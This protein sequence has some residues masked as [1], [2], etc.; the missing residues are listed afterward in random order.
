MVSTRAVWVGAAGLW[1]AACGGVSREHFNAELVTA[2]CEQYVR[3]GVAHDLESCRQVQSW[4]PRPTQGPGSKYD[5]ALK[6]GRI[7]YDE[8]AARRCLDSIRSDPCEEY[9]YWYSQSIMGVEYRPECRFLMGQ[10]VDGEPCQWD[11]ECGRNSYCSASPGTGCFGKCTPHKQVGEQAPS[12]RACAP[13]LLHVEQI[14]R[15]PAEEGQACST[16]GIYPDGCGT[17]LSC[18]TETA[19]C[20]RLQD[21]GEPCD[22]QTTFCQWH[23]VC[24]QGVCQKRQG[25]GGACPVGSAGHDQVI[26]CQWGLSCVGEEGST[27]TCQRVSVWP[28]LP[29]RERCTGS[30][31]SCG[32]GLYCSESSGTCQRRPY[33]GEP[34]PDPDWCSEFSTCW[35][36]TCM[37]FGA[38]QGP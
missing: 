5:R 7:R 23:L 20:Q 8:G 19:V 34:C 18:D 2:L 28:Y 30:A 3:C 1:L 4:Q 6:A 33:L 24:A 27:G 9:P 32:P 17:G 10:L 13:G 26:P 22:R 25:L 21:L 15:Q 12:P 31:Q 36:G 37:V 35:Q 11:M 16:L 14:C 38:C 29:E